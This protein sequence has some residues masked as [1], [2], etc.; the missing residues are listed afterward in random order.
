VGR[1][2]GALP[3][4]W[5]ARSAG[6]VAADAEPLDDLYGTAAYRR[7]A[8]EVLARRALAPAAVRE[9]A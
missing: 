9:A 2:R 8:V 5:R 7:R 3:Q 1:A 4:T 6:L